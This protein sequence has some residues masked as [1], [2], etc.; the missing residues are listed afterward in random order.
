MHA[1]TLILIGLCLHDSELFLQMKSYCEAAAAPHNAV[2]WRQPSVVLLLPL[3]KDIDAEVEAE[4]RAIG[5]EPVLTSQT[6]PH[7]P[8]YLWTRLLEPDVPGCIVP[9][10]VGVIRHFSVAI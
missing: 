2:A 10:S 1:P 9:K 8:F 7:H 4:M 6:Y 3:M 5:C